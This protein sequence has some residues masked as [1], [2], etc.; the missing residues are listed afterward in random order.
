MTIYIIYI[1][2]ISW[3]NNKHCIC[4]WFACSNFFVEITYT[5]KG[6]LVFVACKNTFIPILYINSFGPSVCDRAW[7]EGFVFLR[8]QRCR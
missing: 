6:V 1:Y 5:I 7:E 4:I 3:Q 2:G 8:V